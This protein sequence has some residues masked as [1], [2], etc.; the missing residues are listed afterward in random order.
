MTT[1]WFR[2]SGVV[3]PGA[4]HYIKARLPMPEFDLTDPDNYT[5]GVPHDVF[6]ELRSHDPVSWRSEKSGRG[7]WAVTRY[8]DVV[9]VLKSPRTYSSWLGGALLADPPPEF[10]EKLRE[11]MLNR[12]PPEHTMLRRLV[13]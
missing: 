3:L 6:R 11:G 2:T 10:L 7:Y 9:A 12:D 1:T 8:D 4:E 5:L 13:N